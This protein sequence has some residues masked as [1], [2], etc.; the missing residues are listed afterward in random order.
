MKS[1]FGWPLPRA[2]RNFLFK[3]VEELRFAPPGPIMVGKGRKTK[4]AE[5]VF[6]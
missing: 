3:P 4:K 2:D 6:V 1:P 5:A